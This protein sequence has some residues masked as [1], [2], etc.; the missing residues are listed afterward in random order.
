MHPLASGNDRIMK[1]GDLGYEVIVTD[2]PA[3]YMENL[4]YNIPTFSN[5]NV[6][7]EMIQELVNTLSESDS[8]KA[9][10]FVKTFTT[11]NGKLRKFNQL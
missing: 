4:N 11:K 5:E 1:V 10:R 2:N 6:S 3:F 8:N 9:K 7:E